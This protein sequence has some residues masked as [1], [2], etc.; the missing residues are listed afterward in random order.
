MFTLDQAKELGWT[1]ESDGEDGIASK[2]GE[3]QFQV[4]SGIPLFSMLAEVAEL[5]GFERPPV[6]S[7][8]ALTGESY[9]EPPVPVEEPAPLTASESM[10]AELETL[11]ADQPIT[12]AQLAQALRS[13][14]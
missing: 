8:A 9:T 14:S 3:E 5:E 10:I 1:F 2:D 7:V 11:P 6:V 12:A 13:V 4:G